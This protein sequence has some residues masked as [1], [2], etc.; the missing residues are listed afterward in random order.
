M[1][2]LFLWATF[3]YVSSACGYLA[4]VATSEPAV[5]DR[6]CS[7]TTECREI[8]EGSRCAEGICVCTEGDRL[9]VRSG[10]WYCIKLA[11]PA[12]ETAR[13]RIAGEHFTT[14]PRYNVVTVIIIVAVLVIA[15][16][17]LISKRSLY[18]YFPCCMRHTHL[19]QTVR[20]ECRD[21]PAAVNLSAADVTGSQVLLTQLDPPPS[22]AD[23][24]LSVQRLPTYQEASHPT[25]KPA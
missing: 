6:N 3:G 21:N 13:P 23:A 10:K 2:I 1:N 22:Y 8:D 5:A 20:A 9:I 15:L 7:D 24:V 14:P 12:R 16:L 4:F 11:F 19:P 18:F 25:S 17:F